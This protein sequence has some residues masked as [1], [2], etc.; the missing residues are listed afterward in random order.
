[1]DRRNFLLGVATGVLGNTLYD[2]V[3][4]TPL[5]DGWT[6]LSGLVPANSS[7]SERFAS[8]KTNAVKSLFSGR[9]EILKIAGGRAHYRFPNEMHPD[10]QW[11]CELVVGYA[12]RLAERHQFDSEAKIPS[13]EGS[14][15]C[16]GSPVSNA[17]TRTFFE[18]VYIDETRPA[19]GLRRLES[20]AL[21]LPFQFELRTNV[22]GG[23][24]TSLPH[25]GTEP[26][27]L[28]RN[29]SI[30]HQNGHLF[31]PNV[32]DKLDFLLISRIPNWIEQR[33]PHSDFKNNVTIIGGTHGVGTSSLGLLLDDLDLLK[34]ILLKTSQ[35]EYWQVL[36]TVDKMELGVHPHSNARRHIAKSINPNFLCEPINI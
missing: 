16:A 24:M 23:L 33:V 28:R 29:W 2:G 20:P 32:R 19:L 30:R 22:L 3:V 18:Y 9:G 10:D 15:V 27:K 35:Y 34:K 4:R 25:A 11:A 6:W 8:D 36:L 21:N 17:F 1:M 5:Q 7:F 13:W 26:E 14:F 31:I 12:Q